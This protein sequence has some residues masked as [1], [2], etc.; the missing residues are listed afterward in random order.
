MK[1]LKPSYFI[2]LGIDINWLKILQPVLSSPEMY[3]TM[4][5]VEKLYKKGNVLP[6]KK[7]WF[8]A[9]KVTPYDK[10]KVL[11]IGQ[12]PYHDI[13]NGKPTAH[14]LAFSYK[15]SSNIDAYEPPSLKNILREVEIDIHDGMCFGEC[16]ETDLTRWAKQGVLLFN[17]ALTVEQGKPSSHMSIWKPI[18]QQFIKHI[19]LNNPGLICM[20]WGNFAKGLK[21]YIHS[22][23][24]ILESGHPSPL[25]AN[26]GLWFGNKHFSKAN[27][28]IE[29]LNG[30]EYIIKW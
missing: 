27:Q 22:N 9:F 12:D 3:Y 19:T 16:L 11:I 4:E 18:T 1:Q 20:L 8:N 30:K 14:G 13:K 6:Y 29:K 5:Q 10:L 28:I 17:T 21:P 2:N 15:P 23:C 7:D 24:H 26:Q 25:S